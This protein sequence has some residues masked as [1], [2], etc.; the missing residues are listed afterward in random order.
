MKRVG[1]PRHSRDHCITHFGGIKADA[2][3][4]WISSKIVRCLDWCHT[5]TPEFRGTA[6][7]AQN[8]TR[9]MREH[10]AKES[11]L[12]IHEFSGAIFVGFRGNI[13]YFR[14]GNTT[15]LLCL[16]DKS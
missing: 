6:K 12:P 8:A 2:K 9:A 14:L 3:V 5:T 11:S 7:I 13:A 16:L 15:G 1:F 10:F 4:W